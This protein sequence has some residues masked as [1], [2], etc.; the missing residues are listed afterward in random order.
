MQ[1]LWV[2]GITIFLFIVYILYRMYQS[3]VTGSYLGI[4]TEEQYQAYRTERYALQD[5][6]G[7][8]KERGF[9]NDQAKAAFE[10]EIEYLNK[11]YHVKDFVGKE[12]VR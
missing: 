5:K 12:S 7:Y 2:I 8:C 4:H 10:R 9:I 3:Y 6:Y 11:K 1:I